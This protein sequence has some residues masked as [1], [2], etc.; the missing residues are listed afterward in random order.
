[1]R[2][3]RRRKMEG[4]KRGR[5]GRRWKEV[6]GGGRRWRGGRRKGRGGGGEDGKQSMASI[7]GLQF[8]FL[9]RGMWKEGENFGFQNFNKICQNLPKF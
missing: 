5:G 1:V 8:Y 4:E 3:R 6:E 2:G 7:H 9:S